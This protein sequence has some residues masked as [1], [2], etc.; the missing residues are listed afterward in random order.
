M[1]AADGRRRR[2]L[3]LERRR[4]AGDGRLLRQIHADGG[5]GA[6]D[7]W[8]RRS[9]CACVNICRSLLQIN[10]QYFFFNIYM[11]VVL[12]GS[13][14]IHSKNAHCGQ[15]IGESPIDHQ[16]LHKISNMVGIH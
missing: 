15:S 7:R 8:A 5:D 14:Y 6:G 9:G 1:R 4:A 11:S 10:L 13:M 3:G 16:T 2:V 12:C